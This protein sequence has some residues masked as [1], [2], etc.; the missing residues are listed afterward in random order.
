MEVVSLIVFHFNFSCLSYHIFTVWYNNN[1]QFVCKMENCD[2][3]VSST[4][5]YTWSCKSVSCSC[6]PQSSFCGGPGSVAN[7]AGSIASADGN[8]AFQCPLS[9]NNS[10]TINST[11]GAMNTNSSNFSD[12]Y[13]CSA[14]CMC[15]ECRK[16]FIIYLISCI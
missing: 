15:H 1:E 5:K 16:I 14:S 9:N 7:L 12:F 2:Y 3:Q 8:F 10:S 11:P 4:S 6:I 13:N